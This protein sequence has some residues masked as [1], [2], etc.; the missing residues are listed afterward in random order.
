MSQ[1]LTSALV[2]FIDF[3]GHITP[4]PQ[5]PKTLSNMMAVIVVIVTIVI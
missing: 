2:T 1:D 5:N 4:K 3:E